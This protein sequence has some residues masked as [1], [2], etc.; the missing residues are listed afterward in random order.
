VEF[1]VETVGYL[2]GEWLPPFALAAAFVFGALRGK[3]SRKWRLAAVV[4]VALSYLVVADTKDVIASTDVKAATNILANVKTLEDLN[5]AI[6]ENR[7]NQLMQLLRVSMPVKQQAGQRVQALLESLDD[8]ELDWQVDLNSP[9]RLL[10]KLRK[11]KS[12]MVAA[13][14]KLPQIF[15]EELSAVRRA[16]AEVQVKEKL[17]ASVTD[18]FVKTAGKETETFKRYLEAKVKVL[19]AG[20]KQAAF[21]ININ[22]RYKWD[23]QVS[24]FAFFRDDDLQTY[25]KY[26]DDLA[27]AVAELE[28]TKAEVDAMGPTEINNMVQQLRPLRLR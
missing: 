2:L 27:S 7:D 15:D 20:G 28:R 10:N 19:N 9:Q 4:A 12:N 26:A 21:L 8:K 13:Q 25:N 3:E 23:S 14:S 18:Y 11:A 22:G 16:V 24:R 1:S 6:N 5:K 17:R